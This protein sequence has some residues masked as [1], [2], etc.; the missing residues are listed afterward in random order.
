MLYIVYTE[1]KFFAV[2][3]RRKLVRSTSD[4]SAGHTEFCKS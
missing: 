3:L 1:T 2:T 4:Y